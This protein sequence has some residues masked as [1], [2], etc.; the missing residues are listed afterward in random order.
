M[1]VLNIQLFVDVVALLSG[2]STEQAVFFY[3]DGRLSSEGQGS[4][5]LVSAVLPG[6]FVRW[7]VNPI[8]VQTQIWIQQITFDG[9][10]VMGNG[11]EVETSTGGEGQGHQAQPAETPDEGASAALAPEGIA[12][13]LPQVP[14]WGRG[15]EGFVPFTML[16]GVRYPYH[17]ELSCGISGGN[18]I[19]IDG[20]ALLF[21]ALPLCEQSQADAFGV[22]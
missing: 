21:P 20:P 8:D 11:Q 5:A 19:R 1:A 13:P 22:L 3:D 15:F 10:P 4:P 16:P 14:V 9:A 12:Y 6:Q 2:A 7:A 18:T 17:V